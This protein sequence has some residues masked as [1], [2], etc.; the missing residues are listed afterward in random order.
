[1]SRVVSLM[2]AGL[3][4]LGSSA[5][6]AEG[7]QRVMYNNP[8]LVVDLGVGLWAWPVPWDVDGVQWLRNIGTRT[9]PVLA[10]WNGD[11]LLDLAMLD[12]EGFLS[13]FERRRIGDQ[14]KLMP[15]RRAFLDK[16]AQPLLLNGGRAGK[17]G[18]RKLC[19]TDWDGDGVPR[20]LG[21]RGRRLLL[22]PAQSTIAQQTS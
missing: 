1:M 3:W 11:G 13:L 6:A 12:H 5:F 2:L 9:T 8:G 4:L 18:R 10:D 15:P 21:R 19:A 7:L 17:S 20:F 16:K 14:L 22:F